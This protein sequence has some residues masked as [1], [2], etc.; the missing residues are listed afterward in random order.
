MCPLVDPNICWVFTLMS[1]T[2]ACR[3][4]P[5]VSVAEAG[6]ESR[7]RLSGGGDDAGLLLRSR[8]A[9]GEAGPG[10]RWAGIPPVANVFCCKWKR[11]KSINRGY[12]EVVVLIVNR[13]KKKK[14]PCHLFVSSHCISQPTPKYSHECSV[15]ASSWCDS[16]VIRNTF[17]V[18][19][20]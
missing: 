2:E 20:S 12:S 14:N 5:C 15:I 8:G 17:E 18:A 9:A 11:Q 10:R 19:S 16:C 7:R 1:L 6:D 4:C 3:S 13:S